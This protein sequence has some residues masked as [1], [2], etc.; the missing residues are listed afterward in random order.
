MRGCMS[1]S[2]SSGSLKNENKKF[3]KL[4]GRPLKLKFYVKMKNLKN[5]S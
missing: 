1:D 2:R 5:V 4:V 3:K